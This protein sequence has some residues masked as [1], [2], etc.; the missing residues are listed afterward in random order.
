[1]SET[2]YRRK[3][4][5]ISG[6]HDFGFRYFYPMIKRGIPRIEKHEGRKVTM[7]GP[8]GE[9][10]A[11]VLR[12]E[13]TGP[14]GACQTEYR[15]LGW[16]DIAAKRLS[17]PGWL[18]FFQ[19]PKLM[20]WAGS[21][22]APFSDLKRLH[23]PFWLAAMLAT[24]VTII[25]TFVMMGLFGWAG[26]ELFGW[27]LAK[28][29]SMSDVAA[30]PQFNWAGAI[31]GGVIGGMVAG[32]LLDVLDRKFHQRLIIEIWQLGVEWV[33]G[34]VPAVDGAMDEFANV[35]VEALRDDNVDEV[36]V[37]GHSWG[38]VMATQVMDRALLKLKD[39]AMGPNTLSLLNLGAV[40]VLPCS[41]KPDSL[42]HQ[43][44]NRLT[45]EERLD[46]VE[47]FSPADPLNVPFLN[48]AQAILGQSDA[49]KPAM[50]SLM[51]SHR[52][53]PERFVE[54]KKNFWEMHFH[55]LKEADREAHFSFLRCMT[56]ATPLI[57]NYQVEVDGVRANR[58]QVAA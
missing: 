30:G 5:F 41:A 50:R 16:N 11:E 33:H 2:P 43:A 12:F 47:I 20:W 42:H 51:I 3:V 19:I 18:K 37:V 1:M 58:K 36:L 25:V 29:G 7:T 9:E 56:A 46:W 13:A 26:G 57:L 6:F 23:R 31:T 8:E 40:H 55:Y 32:W 39:E 14:E 52:M 49:D 45:H 34:K 44:L 54:L 38:S 10:G 35:L 24:W 22:T 21:A 48:P 27:L 28:Y 17:V 4:F 15:F 53:A